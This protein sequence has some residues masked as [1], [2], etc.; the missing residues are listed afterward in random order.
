[1]LRPDPMRD[2]IHE[3]KK[4]NVISQKHGHNTGGKVSC[5][6]QKVCGPFFQA[7]EGSIIYVYPKRLAFVVG[8]CYC[9]EGVR[10]NVEI[11]P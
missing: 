9:K 11:L 8:S 2:C 7:T 6:A 10:L 4:S 1:M 5:N 3:V